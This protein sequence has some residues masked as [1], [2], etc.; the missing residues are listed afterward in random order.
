MVR[1]VIIDAG[2]LS[3]IERDALDVDAVL[4]LDD[5]AIATV[6]MMRLWLV[7]SARTGHA[8][9]PARSTSRQSR[10]ALHHRH[11]PSG[12]HAWRSRRWR[13]GGHGRPTI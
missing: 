13:R 9:K 3:A 1:R 12:M 11:R 6:T 5:A 8:A 4:G 2:V 10:R 7:L